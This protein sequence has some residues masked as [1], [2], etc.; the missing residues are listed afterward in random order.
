MFIP[1]SVLVSLYEQVLWLEKNLERHILA[2][3]YFENLKALA[4]S[5]AFFAGRYANRWRQKAGRGLLAQLAEQKLADGG[6]YERTPQYHSLMLENYLDLY[7]VVSHNRHLFEPSLYEAL[8]VAA[9]AGLTFLADIV[10]PDRKIPL[11]NDSAFDVAPD[12]DELECYANRLFPGEMFSPDSC[13]TADSTLIDKPH[14]RFYGYRQAQDMIVVECGAI[15]PSYQPGHT[16]CGLLSYELMVAG[17]RVIVD[18]G[19]CE[20]EPGQLRQIVRS[21][22]AHN[23]VSVDGADQ[24]EIWGEF[25]VAR[26]AKVMSAGI[27]RVANRILFWG[28]RWVLRSEGRSHAYSK[29]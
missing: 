5:S 14:S 26:R 20:Y 2:N 27:S 28:V 16:H 21:T 15:S 12:F 23:T 29:N 11:F 25:R 7:N 3:H 22:R 9:K 17:E 18:S 13:G 10:F 4:F 6:H 1:H 24:S 8:Q 19:V